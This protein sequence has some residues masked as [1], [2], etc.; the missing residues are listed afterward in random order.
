MA[1]LYDALKNISTANCSF[2]IAHQF[3]DFY[4]ELTWCGLVD[5]GSKSVSIG[6]SSLT[7][8]NGLFQ[9]IICAATARVVVVQGHNITKQS[10]PLSRDAR[11]HLTGFRDQKQREREQK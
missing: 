5:I 11:K 9:D 6:K 8:E 1:L 10:E 7:I 4:A 2:V 3:L